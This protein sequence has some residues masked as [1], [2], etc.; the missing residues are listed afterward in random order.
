MG[1]FCMVVKEYTAHTCIKQ[2]KKPHIILRAQYWEHKLGL[3]L[4]L[5]SF[6][7]FKRKIHKMYVFVKS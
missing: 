2:S 6:T 1:K 7:Y 4:T 5:L 3:D